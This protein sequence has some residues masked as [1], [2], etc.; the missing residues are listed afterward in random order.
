M[1]QTT[2]NVHDMIMQYTF[3]EMAKHPDVMM[4]KLGAYLH[5]QHNQYNQT[6]E[7]V[8]MAEPTIENLYDF[9]VLFDRV[10][11]ASKQVGAHNAGVGAP[12]SNNRLYFDARVE[13]RT[14]VHELIR[15]SKGVT[16][17]AKPEPELPYAKGG[18]DKPS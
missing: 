8:T 3:D 6:K 15:K 7:Q 17:N 13:L 10:T 1:A 5:N 18:N 11:N 12:G 2:G 9:D 14:A 4:R 16:T